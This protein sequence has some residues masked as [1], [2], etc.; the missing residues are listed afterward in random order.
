MDK[1]QQP[2]ESLV[3]HEPDRLIRLLN[4]GVII[5]VKV[6]AVLI[7]IVIFWGV[8][9]VIAHLYQQFTLQPS[10]I[11]YAE[12]LISILGS[13]LIVLIAIEVFLNIIFYLKKD[14]LQVHL[15]LA[16]ALT[17]IARKVIVFDY[18]TI[19]PAYIY[20]TAAVIVAIGITYWLVSKSQNGDTDVK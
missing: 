2:Q 17:A 11:F 3:S 14:A 12:N 18:S 20:A 1:P 9:D 8:L 7:T 4:K 5:S 19:A 6:L 15:V 13:F 16:T 10:G